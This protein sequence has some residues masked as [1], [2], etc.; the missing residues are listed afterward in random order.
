MDVIRKIERV[1]NLLVAVAV[2]YLLVQSFKSDDAI[3]YINTPRLLSEYEG[4]GAAQKEVENNTASM[5]ANVDTLAAELQAAILKY[6]KDRTSLSEKARQEAEEVLRNKQIQYQ[7]YQQAVSQKISDED[8]KVSAA[9]LAQMTAYINE[10][11]RKNNYKLILGATTT[12][13]IVFADTTGDVTDL[14]LRGLN[15]EYKNSK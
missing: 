5:R 7:Q 14:I 1:G 8:N 15:D 2:V 13:N 10:F 3:V 4:L 6:E 12:G 11:G 9:V